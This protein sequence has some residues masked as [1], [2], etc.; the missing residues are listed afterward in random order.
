MSDANEKKTKPTLSLGKKSDG[1][2]TLSLKGGSGGSGGTLS[3]PGVAGRETA[4]VKQQFARGRTHSVAVEVK[5]PKSLRLGGT[6]PAQEEEATP[7]PQPRVAGA[8][9]EAEAPKVEAEAS[10]ANLSEEE[11]ARRAAVLKAAEEDRKK[12]EAEE[13]ERAAR[14][15][16]ERKKREAEELVRQQREAEEAAREKAAGQKLDPDELRRRELEELKKI[17]DAER[18][19]KEAENALRREE[20]ERK[21]R[22]QAAAERR[23]AQQRQ[24]QAASGPGGS[25][26]GG[27]FDPTRPESSGPRK[28]GRRGGQD[29]HNQGGRRDRRGGGRDRNRGKLT[30]QSALS[31]NMEG[32]MRSEAARRRARNKRQQSEFNA[33]VEKKSREVT[34]PEVITVQELA[35][36]MAERAAEVV[37]TLMGMGVMATINQTIDVDTAELVIEEMGH[38]IKRVSE[39]DVEVGLEGEDDA[40]ENLKPRAPVVTVMGHVDHGKTSLL[41]ALRR[42]DVVA[43][44]AGGITQ[45]IGAYQVQLAS[46]DRITF[47]DT[48]GH[49]AFSEMRSRGANVT[50]IVILVVAANDSIMPQTVEAISHAK[51]A[52]VPIIV[53]INKCDLP[54]ANPDKVRQDLLSHELVVEEMGG[55]VVAVEISAKQGTGL[56]ALEEAV[57][58]HAEMLELKANPDRA[59]IGT[60]VES[61]MEVGRGSV[62]TVLVQKGTLSNGDIFVAGTEWG[63]VRAL[64]NDRGKPISSAGPASPVEVLGLQGTPNAGDSF[65]VVDHEAKAREITEYR[66]RKERDLSSV[67]S[68]GGGGGLEAMFAQLAEGEKKTLPVVIKADVHGSVEAIAGSLA[69]LVEENDEIDVRVLHGGVGGINESDIQLARASNALVVGFNVRANPQ[70]RDLAKREGIEIRYY[71][72]IYNVIDDAKALLTGMLAPTYK[73]NFIGNAEIREVFNITKVGKVA[74]CFVTN[75][76]VKRGAGVRLLRDDVVIHEGK[77]KTLKRFKD[78]VK[79]VREGYECGMAFEAYDDMKAGDVI[80]A[81]EVEEIA[82]EL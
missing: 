21:K 61:R 72:V 75:G 20:E 18:E 17:Q 34:V 25:N 11:M 62:A 31:G 74:G 70:A 55:D 45:H 27:G 73:E 13:A 44:E 53:A 35:N 32:R 63:R 71:S 1:K 10:K 81:F 46:G 51:A 6:E 23:A 59:C 64:M 30:I 49:A 9:A 39:A 82:S 36:R 38:T 37:K 42:T 40:D 15:E 66:Q 78:E 56:E 79:D 7:R 43:G 41:D 77:L 67:A 24:A 5:R 33:P 57:L 19:K 50:D 58:L 52:E 14:E 54:E 16:E 48:P 3:A 69:K 4:R 12:R 60:V 26:A 22:E 65:I 8:E 68:A 29:D 76:I 28:K 2:K 47:I 80:E